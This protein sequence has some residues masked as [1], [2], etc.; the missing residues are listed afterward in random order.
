MEQCR[1]GKR[2]QE[3]GKERKSE[4]VDNNFFSKHFQILSVK[5]H[6]VSKCIE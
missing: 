4:Q 5:N 6:S 2:F 3:R 1:K